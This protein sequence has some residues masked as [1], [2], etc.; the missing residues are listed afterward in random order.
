MACHKKK[1]IF[2]RKKIQSFQ[3]KGFSVFSVVW[4]LKRVYD[5]LSLSLFTNTPVNETS[6]LYLCASCS[7][8]CCCPFEL[9]T[10]VCVMWTYRGVLS[11][12][13][14]RRG[15]ASLD[16][17]RSV[18]T[19]YLIRRHTAINDAG[20]LCFR[21]TQKQLRNQGRLQCLGQRIYLWVCVPA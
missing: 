3:M 16:G 7:W 8:I 1:I 19:D 14:A 6:Y 2:G 5:I 21:W 13:G 4:N 10:H 11:G 17:E 18:A 9:V 15:A 20:T 12:T